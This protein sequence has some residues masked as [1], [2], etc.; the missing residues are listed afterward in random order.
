M[1][2]ALI[3]AVQ[4]SQLFTEAINTVLGGRNKRATLYL[5]PYEMHIF[6]VTS[7][8]DCILGIDVTTP[9]EVMWFC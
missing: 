9:L 8:I 4:I 7:S 6:A 3:A 5:T 2:K 1:T